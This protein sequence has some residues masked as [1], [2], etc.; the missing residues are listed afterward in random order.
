MR[1]SNFLCAWRE[2]PCEMAA[3]QPRIGIDHPT[4]V[5]APPPAED[6]QSPAE[7]RGRNA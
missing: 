1:M 5:P 7:K 3:T 2:G 4:V 6:E